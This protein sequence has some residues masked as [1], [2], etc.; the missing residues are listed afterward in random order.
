MDY[1]RIYNQIIQRAQ[2][3]NRVKTKDAYYEIHHIIPRCLGG[4]N[5]NTNLVLLTARE[6]F[7]CHLILCRLH[8]NN[9]KLWYAA[10][11][12][13]MRQSLK[14]SSRQYAEIKGNLKHSDETRR[15]MSESSKGR[16]KGKK[17]SDETK[18]KLREAHKN[19]L[20]VSEETR[21][22]ISDANKGRNVSITIRKNLSA[23]NKVKPKPPRSQKHIDS[24]KRVAKEKGFKGP[25][26]DDNWYKAVSKPIMQYTKENQAIKQWESI[27]QASN[28]LKINRSDIGSVCNG[29]YKSAGGFIWKFVY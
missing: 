18:A 22:K 4:N 26:K 20:P 23:L 25:I 24:L 28:E 29:R 19:R 21:K 17:L 3:E 10:N 12:M 7:I 15:K 14:I 9:H 13:L 1:Q 16:G 2:G 6:H 8:K 11:A 27:Q 5:E